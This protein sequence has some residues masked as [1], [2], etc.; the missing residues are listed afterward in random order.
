ML[1]PLPSW[2]VSWLVMPSPTCT[3]AVAA[4]LSPLGCFIVFQLQC[5]I[6]FL[7]FFGPQII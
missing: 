5:L 1:V 2:A 7:R 6:F 3:T 4:T